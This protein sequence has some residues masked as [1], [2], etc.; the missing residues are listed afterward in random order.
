MIALLAL[1]IAVF[2]GALADLPTDC[3]VPAIEPDLTDIITP[4]ERIVGGKEV[5]ENSWP[6]QIQLRYNGNFLCGGSVIAEDWVLT[7]AHCVDG[8][9]TSAYSVRAGR[10]TR[11]GVDPYE[12]SSD[13]KKIYEHE[14]YTSSSMDNDVALMHVSTPFKFNK[15]VSPVCLTDSDPKGGRDAWVTGW[16]NVKDSCCDGYLKQ[17]LLPIIDRATCG[18]VSN[19]GSTITADMVCAGWDDGSQSACNGDSG[20]PLSVYDEDSERFVQVGVV[21]W[22]HVTCK[23]KPNVYAGVHYFKPWILEKI[24]QAEEEERMAEKKFYRRF[25]AAFAQN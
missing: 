3:G 2:S 17:A 13:V 16:G 12:Q 11:Y 6:W 15:Y 7:A 18:K 9:S 24:A 19:W 8:R 1:S 20:G 4:V 25:G 22:G 21:S 14:Q 23:K 5:K 10:H